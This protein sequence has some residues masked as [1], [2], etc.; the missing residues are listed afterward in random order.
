MYADDTK[1]WRAIHNLQDQD[2]LQ[3]D[4]GHKLYNWSLRSKIAFHPY[5]CK[6]VKVSLKQNPLV[7]N[8]TM[9]NVI[10]EPCNNE[11]DLGVIVCKNFK[12]NLQHKKI[13]SKD[14]QKLGLL[15]SEIYPSLKV[16]YI[17]EIYIWLS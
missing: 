12:W 3:Q 14:S 5:K 13:I 2:V 9:N 11:T 4:I 8:Y 1:I 6:Y 17:E 7:Y 16:K 10:I 15:K